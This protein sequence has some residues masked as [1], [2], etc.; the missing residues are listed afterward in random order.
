MTYQALSERV[1]LSPRPCLERVRRLEQKGVIRGYAALIEPLSV[2]HDIIALAGIT[3]RDPVRRRAAAS[4]TRA[5]RPSVRRRAAGGERRER[6]CGR[7][8]R[9]DA[10]GLRGFDRGLSGRSGFRD[11]P[12]PHDLR[13]EDPQ[14]FR[15]LSG[16]RQPGLTR[17]AS[18]TADLAGA[19]GEFSPNG[20]GEPLGLSGGG[21]HGQHRSRKECHRRELRSAPRRLAEAKGVWVTDTDGKRYLDM[22]SAY[23]AVSLGHGHPRILKA[24]MEQASRLAVTSRA[25]HTELLGPF[26]EAPRRS[27]RPRHGA[28][29]EHRRRGGRNR[30]QGGATLGIPLQEHC[31]GSRRNHRRGI[32]IST[33]GRRRSWASRR[34][35]PIATVSARST[36]VS[37]RCRSATSRLWRAPSRRNT[38]AILIEPIQGEAGIVVPPEG[39]LREL[40]AICDRNRRSADPR[41]SP[42]RPRAHRALVRPSA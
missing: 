2:G 6:L 39:Y 3:M 17:R 12:H 23:S 7:Y 30:H 1:G 34:T 38:C 9:A 8:R 21:P 27:H 20:T 35:K 18:A 24:M 40:R 26:L 15:R 33:A 37:G 11:R 32:T 36:A 16:P 42:V 29:D 13:A 19:G 25:Y 41:R 4:R 31:E 5:L 10:R 14:E 22:M 28:A